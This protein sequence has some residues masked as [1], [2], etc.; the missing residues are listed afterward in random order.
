MKTREE[1]LEE[2]VDSL[3]GEIERLKAQVELE[4]DACDVQL[5]RN[6]ILK[7]K[8]EE[9]EKI[10]AKETE[11]LHHF[12]GMEKNQQALIEKIQEAAKPFLKSAE[13]FG[14]EVP[15]DWNLYVYID[16]GG[17][18]T[19][20]KLKDLR[21]FQQACTEGEGLDFSSFLSG[22]PIEDSSHDNRLSPCPDCGE[23]RMPGWRF[24]L[25]KGYVKCATCQGTGEVDDA[26]K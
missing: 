7:Q 17:I 11:A 3:K 14:L 10:L 22:P 20:V 19:P 9:L 8:V 16:W 5:A 26:P 18:L 12:I 1:Y 25:G 2:Q 23:E 6:K 13:T 21:V 4:R 15:D 24:I